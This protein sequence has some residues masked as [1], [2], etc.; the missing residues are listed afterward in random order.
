M[1]LLV[2]D[3]IDLKVDS[4]GDLVFENGDI[5]WTSGLEGVVDQIDLALKDV[6]GEWFMDLDKGMPYF[7][8]D[9]LPA[10]DALMAQVFDEQKALAA[11]R[12]GILEVVGVGEILFLAVDFNGASRK[13]EV[14]FRVRTVFGDSDLVTTE[15]VV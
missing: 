3:P 4:N 8:N 15:V 12:T 9:A 6:R 14:E 7:E 2:T 1:A 5:A 11:F 10:S 13:L